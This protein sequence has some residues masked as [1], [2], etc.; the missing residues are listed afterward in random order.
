MLKTFL[1]AA[2]ASVTLI[3]AASLPALA[4]P[5]KADCAWDSKTVATGAGKA[6]AAFGGECQNGG[7]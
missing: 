1:I 7:E 4:G 3:G 6:N 5:S 2:F